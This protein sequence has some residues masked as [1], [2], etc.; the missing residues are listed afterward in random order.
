MTDDKATPAQLITAVDSAVTRVRTRALDVSFNELFD[1]Y[2]SGELVISPEY[3]R[4]F[5]W[6]ESKQSQFI[7]SLILE[8]PIPP[9]YLIEVEDG[10][11]EL[12]DGLQRIS[13]Y[14][15]FRGIHPNKSDDEG[16]GL[17]L[18]GCDVL[19]DLNGSTYESLP[20]AIQIKL[21]RHF[22]RMEVL[23]RETENQFR[24]HMFKRLNT[25]GEILS[26]QEIRNCTIRLLDNTFNDFLKDMAKLPSYLECMEQLTD[27][28]REQ[29]YL[30]EYVLRFF[31]LKN[32]REGYSKEVGEFLT[33]YMESVADSSKSVSFDYRVEKAAFET[34]FDFLN[35]A[36]GNGAFSGYNS[37]GNPMGYFSSLHFEAFSLGL[38]KY[39]GEISALDQDER[40]VVFEGLRSIKSDPEF[41]RLT[42][43]GG[44]NYSAAL[45]QRVE[46]VE[47]KVAECL[48]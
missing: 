2:R 9:I 21:K 33:S 37:R 31:A 48:C 24:Y 7:E 38:Q 23:R 43:G 47:R 13:S 25:G 34:T 10:I 19:P 17:V 4:L 16:G 20:Q 8:L 14:F 32:N 3:Q 30:E 42:T 18:T 1:M 41:K 26:P 35:E 6:P 5:R 40:E 15:H 29:M 45:N 39:L 11:Y 28:K 46:F 27:E 36:F 44:K 22:I 12:I